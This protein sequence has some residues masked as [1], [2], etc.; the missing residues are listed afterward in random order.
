M[1]MR[2]TD[3]GRGTVEIA[4]R[5][6]GIAD[7]PKRWGTPQGDRFSEERQ[8]WIRRNIE[9]DERDPE[10]RQK[11]EYMRQHRALSRWTDALVA[12]VNDLGD[13]SYR[14]ERDAQRREDERERRYGWTREA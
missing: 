9:E 10:F 14:A 11:K 3:R 5:A 8:A 7:F 2:I 6:R 12:T 4:A 13:V 1:D